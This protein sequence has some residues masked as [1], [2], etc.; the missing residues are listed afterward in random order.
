M[1]STHITPGIKLEK[2]FYNYYELPQMSHEDTVMFI[3]YDLI[4]KIGLQCLHRYCSVVGLMRFFPDLF[5]YNC[6]NHH[7]T[8]MS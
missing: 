8:M 5:G 7:H 2:L 6:N 1:S 3:E 4:G